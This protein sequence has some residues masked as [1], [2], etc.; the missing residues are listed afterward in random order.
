MTHRAGVVRCKGQNKGNVAGRTQK[1][2]T[3]EK[4]Y[5]KG[6]DCNNDIRG[7][8]LRQKL[9]SKREF[10]KTFRE[11]LGLEVMEQ[12]VTISSGLPKVRD[13][14]LWRGWLPTQ[15]KSQKCRST[16]HSR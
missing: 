3:Y 10:N 6:A 8:C 2:W 14:T 13:W 16:G 1:E 9:Q 15:S 4:T 12:A 7:W 5:W 11:T